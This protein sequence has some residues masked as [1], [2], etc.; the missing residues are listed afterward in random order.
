[1]RYCT[2]GCIPYEFSVEPL[3][4]FEQSRNGVDPEV[5]AAVAFQDRV[6]DSPV[7][8]AVQVFCQDL[9]EE[10]EKNHRKS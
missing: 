2:Y 3:I 5:V 9:E 6:G 4:D 8:L 1:V 10:E 7:H